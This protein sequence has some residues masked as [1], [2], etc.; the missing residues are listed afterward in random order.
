LNLAFAGKRCEFVVLVKTDGASSLQSGLVIIVAQ[1]GND[2]VQT[3]RGR[4]PLCKFGRIGKH[5]G[6]RTAKRFTISNIV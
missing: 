6:D 2:I 4:S 5:L 3:T 1:T